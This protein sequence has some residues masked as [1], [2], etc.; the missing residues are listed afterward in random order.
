LI[1]NGFKLVKIIFP[2]KSIK[3]MI[4]RISI[5]Y[6]MLGCLSSLYFRSKLSPER[7]D[8]LILG[9]LKFDIGLLYLV[10]LSL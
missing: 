7:K 1:V 5:S 6:V 3:L 8:K 10:E 9:D 2:I 4:K